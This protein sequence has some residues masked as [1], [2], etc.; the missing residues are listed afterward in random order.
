MYYK[1]RYLSIELWLPLASKP[2]IFN[3]DWRITFDIIKN[4]STDYNSFNTAEVSIY[5][6]EPNLI[7]QMSQAGSHIKIVGGYKD[8]YGLLF[9]GIVNNVVITKDDTDIITTLHCASEISSLSNDATDC[10]TMNVTDYLRNLCDKNN[11]KHDIAQ[12]NKDLIKYSVDKTVIEAIKEIC[13]LFDL[14]YSIDNGVL[15]VTPKNISMESVSKTDI[16][17]IDPTTGLIGNPNIGD[18][19]CRIKSLIDY[20]YH[21]NGYF[22]LQAKYATY[23]ISQ[24]AYRPNA[25][26]GNQLNALM[27]IDK[28]SYNG[29]YMILY[30]SINGDT[31]GNNWYTELGGIKL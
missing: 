5:N 9:T 13:T 12:I 26:L 16:V 15:R 18:A 7:N 17:T 20:R 24:L 31:R 19:E 10:I 4:A 1:D 21:V 28:N 29:T 22:N 11:I 8:L 30:M 14:T 23:N 25:I 27:Y 6:I 3:Q 2:I